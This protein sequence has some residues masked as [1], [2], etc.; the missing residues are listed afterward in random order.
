MKSEET[1]D[2]V[3]LNEVDNTIM[4]TA[5]EP[6]LHPFGET[7]IAGRVYIPQEDITNIELAYLF[8]LFVRVHVV[9]EPNKQWDF[10]KYIKEHNLDR[11]FIAK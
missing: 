11:H 5:A 1:K 4:L 9:L 10:E 2:Q 3:E 7:I 8:E 6:S